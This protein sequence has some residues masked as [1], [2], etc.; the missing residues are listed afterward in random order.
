MMGDQFLDRLATVAASE[1]PRAPRRSRKIYIVKDGKYVYT[2]EPKAAKVDFSWQDMAAEPGK[3]SY[4][5][6]RG[7]QS[8]GEIVWASPMWITY[9]GK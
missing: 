8:N 5:Y 1:V 4:Y 3:M 9:T 6:V 7:E 2:R